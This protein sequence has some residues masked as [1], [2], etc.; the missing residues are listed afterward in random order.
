[1]VGESDLREKNF[2][3][4]ID[5][6]VFVHAFDMDE[7]TK[8]IKATELIRRLAA[9]AEEGILLWQVAA[10][11][12]RCLRKW[13]SAGQM[14]EDVRANFS[15][16]LRTFPLELPSPAIFSISFELC[17]RFSLSHWDSLLL[18]SCKEAGVDTLHTEDLSDGADY[19]GV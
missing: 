8:R 13:E 11:F 16:V 14:G 6:N 12:F 19:D 4:A 15:G 7:P 3:S 18:A 17:S 5:T 2:M 10:E 9:Q 1:M